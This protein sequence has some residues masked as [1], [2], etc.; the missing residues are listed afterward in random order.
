MRC[1]SRTSRLR[2]SHPVGV[3]A[4]SPITNFLTTAEY[5]QCVYQKG[6]GM[7]HGIREALGEAAFLSALRDYIDAYAYGIASRED[8]TLSLQA[9]T[10]LSWR[11][12]IDDYLDE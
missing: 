8:F 4:G 12:F 2:I 6:A 7:L 10:G 5:G 1:M 9:S 3:T 11:G